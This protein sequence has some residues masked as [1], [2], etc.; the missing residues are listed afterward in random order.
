MEAAT[1][2]VLRTVRQVPAAVIPLVAVIPQV[3]AAVTPAVVEVTT[4]LFQQGVNEVKVRGE[5]G[6]LNGTPFLLCHAYVSLSFQAV[7]LRAKFR[8]V[9]SLDFCSEINLRLLGPGCVFVRDAPGL[10]PV[11]VPP[12]PTP[13]NL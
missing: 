10:H 6:V 5:K 11:P 3:V 8:P 7:R 2:A 12:S 9:G 1:A 4:R 13:L